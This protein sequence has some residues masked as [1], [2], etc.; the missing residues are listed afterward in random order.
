VR[1]IRRVACV[2]VDPMLEAIRSICE[3]DT[4]IWLEIGSRG[5]EATVGWAS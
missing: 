5:A 2:S 4:T 1:M 3:F